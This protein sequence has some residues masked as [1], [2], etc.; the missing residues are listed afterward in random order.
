[1]RR[2][3]SNFFNLLGLRKT[4]TD[5]YANANV[6]DILGVRLG[7]NV[8]ASRHRKRSV[9][10]GKHHRRLGKFPTVVYDGIANR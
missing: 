2:P 8:L 6:P 4:L 9:E 5:N 10:G 3:K 7:C 1:M